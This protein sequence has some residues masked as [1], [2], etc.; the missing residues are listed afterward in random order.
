MKEIQIKLLE[1]V[2]NDDCQ[3]ENFQNI[4]SLITDEDE[5]KFLSI[6]NLINRVS[7]NHHRSPNFFT[8]LF[9][10]ILYIKPQITKYFTDCEIFYIFQNNMRILLFLIEEKIISVTETIAKRIRLNKYDDYFCPEMKPFF[11]DLQTKELPENFEEKRRI[12]ENDSFICQIIRDDLIDD[13]IIYINQTN[14][15]INSTI[16]QSIFETNNYLISRKLT[17]IEYAAFYGSI[18]I[19]IYLQSKNVELTASLWFD[20]IL[21]RNAELLSRIVETVTKPSHTY[22]FYLELAINAFHNEIAFYII[23]NFIP[24]N[25]NV[26]NLGLKYYNFDFILPET[27]NKSSFFILCQYKFEYLVKILL[28]EIEVNS[29]KNRNN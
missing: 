18:R 17:L 19:F 8:K 14:I 26:E 9:K 11:S 13:F 22:L 20:A 23:D 16:N 5:H 15:N 27:I 6:L 28:K 1:Y 21:G 12:G 29:K 25:E 2:D 3:D 4:I 10:I 24:N 7:E